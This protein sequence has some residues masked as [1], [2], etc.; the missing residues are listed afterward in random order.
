MG[1]N[2][3]HSLTP[4]KPRPDSSGR[5]GD[6]W[7]RTSRD[8]FHLRSEAGGRG[9]GRLVRS[10]LCTTAASQAPCSP[11]SRRSGRKPAPAV[12][13]CWIDPLWNALCLALPQRA[14]PTQRLLEVPD[15]FV[16]RKLWVSF[17][18]TSCTSSSLLG[19]GCSPFVSEATRVP[20]SQLACLS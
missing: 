18:P 15:D 6:R 16:L 8:T 9:L 4:A 5:L 2:W 3:V 19:H 17:A 11:G 10:A 7:Q 20:K 14:I 12:G 13:G 1:E